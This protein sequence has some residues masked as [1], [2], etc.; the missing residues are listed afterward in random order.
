MSVQ[1]SRPETPSN[2]GRAGLHNLPP[3]QRH[4]ENLPYIDQ[5]TW[6]Q[7]V[8]EHPNEYYQWTET[9]RARSKALNERP[10]ISVMQIENEN[11]VQQ[12]DELRV[13]NIAGNRLL[14]QTQNQVNQLLQNQFTKNVQPK[15]TNFR[16]DVPAFSGKDRSQYQLFK[17]LVS[18]RLK[19][20]SAPID[21]Q[22]LTALV[23]A[24]LEGPALDHLYPYL[25]REEDN[26]SIEKIFG[27]LDSAYMDVQR[28]ATAQRDIQT[29]YQAN[30]PF[31]EFIS[32]FRRL[33]AELDWNDSALIAR[34]Q[35][36]MS[37]ELRVAIAP[38]KMPKDLDSFISRCSEVDQALR[39]A[40]SFSRKRS[41]N[42]SYPIHQTKQFATTFPN[43]NIHK[44]TPLASAKNNH[45]PEPMDLS[46]SKHSSKPRAP[47]TPAERQARI[48]SGA[49]LYCGS[50]GHMVSSC[51]R[52]K[53]QLAAAT[54]HCCPSAHSQTSVTQDLIDLGN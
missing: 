42:S 47:L 39:A 21:P 30:K 28:E 18:F 38:F 45:D 37:D 9:L 46:A 2:P 32:Q 17:T 23:L 6:I 20:H 54:V 36:A 22:E 51:P 44:M 24:K 3:H 26:L 25:A 41:G 29:L 7:N 40:H 15:P 10:D 53:I 49:C 1:N 35:V 14:E 31:S 13:S 12:L 4:P 33:Q 52:R 48:D 50:Q 11:L 8:M 5:H 19:S 34:L 43:H 27:V 16:L